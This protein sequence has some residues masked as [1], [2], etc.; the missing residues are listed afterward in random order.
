MALI[1]WAHIKFFSDW[2]FAP[3]IKINRICCSFS[4]LGFS[5]RSAHKILPQRDFGL[6]VGGV[7]GPNLHLRLM[8]PSCRP[9][10]MHVPDGGDFDLRLPV[11]LIFKKI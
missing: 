8:G 7:S 2:F 11:W 5:S 4:D 3:H 10:S 6:R 1:N 9:Y